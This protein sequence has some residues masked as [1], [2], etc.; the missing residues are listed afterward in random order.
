MFCLHSH[1]P[2]RVSWMILVNQLLL[3]YPFFI[4]SVIFTCMKNGNWLLGD[5]VLI[6]FSENNE[7]FVQILC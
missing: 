6:S 5:N 1:F 7:L 2:L 3:F 4:S